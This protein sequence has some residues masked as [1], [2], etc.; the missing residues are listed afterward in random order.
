MTDHLAFFLLGLGNGAVY[1]ALGLALVMTFKSSGVVNFATGAVALYAAYTYAF[2]RQ[3]VLLN[4]IPGFDARIDLGGRL[5]VGPALAG[6]VVIASVLGILLYLIVFRP[7]RSAPVLAKAVASIGL[8]L[9]IQAL[10]A[11]RVGADAPT[12]GPIFAPQSFRVGDATVPTDRIWLA[13]VVVGLAVCAGLVLR[14][15][16]FGVATEAAAE[17]EK[18]ALLTGLSPDRIAISNWALS[19]GTA[20]IGGVVIAPHAGAVPR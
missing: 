1:A 11:L 2:L 9:V 5:G 14:Y 17:S 12:V 10:L 8:M 15:T 13:A 18:G 3:G 19:S 20:A 16:R 7:M 6:A 4:P